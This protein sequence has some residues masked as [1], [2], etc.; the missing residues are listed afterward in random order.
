MT[1]FCFALFL[2]LG[3]TTAYS[4]EN[5]HVIGDTE[6]QQFRGEITEVSIN[7]SYKGCPESLLLN[8]NFIAS[9][10]KV[11]ETAKGVKCSFR[12]YTIGIACY[13]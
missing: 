8:K 6:E 9:L 1:K 12:T 3:L 5:C 13:K 2:F 10:F 11:E 4:M 7:E